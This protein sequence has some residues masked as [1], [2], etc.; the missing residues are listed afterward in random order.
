MDNRKPYTVKIGSDSYSLQTMPANLAN[1]I[2]FTVGEAIGAPLEA[3]LRAVGPDAGLADMF[4][5]KYALATSAQI[6]SLLVRNLGSQGMLS[7]RDSLFEGLAQDNKVIED[8]DAHFAGRIVQMYQLMWRA[9]GENY[10]DFF[11]VLRSLF[12]QLSA[13]SPPESPQG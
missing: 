11:G 7:V 12:G 8:V 5:D 4:K 10:D 3:F 13:E 2:L 9:I 1:D 6:M